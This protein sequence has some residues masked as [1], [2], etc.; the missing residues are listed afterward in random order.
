MK[1]ML[2]FEPEC[3]LC[4]KPVQPMQIRIA[5][6]QE[7]ELKALAELMKDSTNEKEPDEDEETA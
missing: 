1:R 4:S 7:G 3:P 5:E 2:E 6:D